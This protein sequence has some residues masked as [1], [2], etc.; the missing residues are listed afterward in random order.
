MRAL[1]KLLARLDE[2]GVVGVVG[3]V[4]PDIFQE[5]SVLEKKSEKEASPDGEKEKKLAILAG[6]KAKASAAKDAKEKADA[7]ALAIVD[8]EAER[9]VAAL[10]A[11]ERAVKV[12]DSSSLPALAEFDLSRFYSNRLLVGHDPEPGIVAVDSVGSCSSSIIEYVRQSDG[13]T[14]ARSTTFKPFF[15]ERPVGGARLKPRFFSGWKEMLAARNWDRPPLIIRNPVEQYL[16]ETGRTCFK[17]M[18]F[19]ALRRLQLDIETSRTSGYSFSHPDRDPILAIALSDSSGWEEVIVVD[20]GSEAESAALDRLSSIIRT[21]NPDIIEGHNLFKFDLPY[22]MRRA[23]KLGVK[24][25]W[26]RDGSDLFQALDHRGNLRLDSF[27]AGGGAN[28]FRAL[29]VRGRHIVDTYHLAKAWDVI[30]HE[31]GNCGLKNVARVLGVSDPN[32]VILD[33]DEIQQAYHQDRE[34][35]LAYVLADVRDTRGISAVLS[36]SYFVQAQIYPCG[37]QALFTLGAATKMNRLLLREYLRLRESVP[38]APV[39]REFVGALCEIHESG[40]IKDVEHCDVESLYPSVMLEFGC[41][42][43]SDNL[44]VFSTI[45]RDLRDYRLA[46]KRSSKTATDPLVKAELSAL[47]GALKILINSAYGYLATPTMDFADGE[48]AE[49]VTAIGRNILKRMRELLTG[50][51]AHVIELDT[52]GCYFTLPP[53]VSREECAS[54]LRTQLPRGIKVEFDKRFPV[55]FSYLSKNAAFLTEQGEILIKGG[56]L[57]SR[58]DEPFIQEYNKTVIAMLLTGRAS[59]VPALYEETVS[60]ILNHEFPL[61]ALLKTETLGESVD[62]YK[63]KVSAG[64][65]SRGANYEVAITSGREYLAGD[66]VS[67]YIAIGTSSKG[68]NYARAR[69]APSGQ[70]Y[71]RDEDCL[72][73]IKRLNAVA[74]RFDPFAPGRMPWKSKIARKKPENPYKIL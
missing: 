34:K 46:V 11:T 1:D 41:V 68:P 56:S 7:D 14:V 16:L 18:Q 36:P 5:N 21:R 8:A 60:A 47:Q 33:G 35:F 57:K 43:K 28:E 20:G 40:I 49:M 48:A 6:E 73:Y 3:V 29:R 63:G 64:L 39:K 67:Y 25:S 74:E 23:S 15:W 38:V 69:I 19:S 70:G 10:L 51:G 31:F 37:L 61:E 54:G 45:L 62:E 13:S 71:V 24:L 50:L 22:L 9:R 32:R 55:M 58:A 72:H 53:G 2:V 44:G 59:A 12:V 26:G 4:P 65:R 66:S 27:K 52:D 42:P 30:T 17:G